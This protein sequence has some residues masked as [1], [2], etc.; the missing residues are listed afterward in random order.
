M[1]AWLGLHD[2]NLDLYPIY[3]SVVTLAFAFVTFTPSCFAFATISTLFL[4]DTACEILV[5]VS[6]FHHFVQQRNI[7]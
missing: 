1:F 3:D 2:R 4:D 7:L 6:I 5:A